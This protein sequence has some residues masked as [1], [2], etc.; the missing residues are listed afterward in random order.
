MTVSRLVPGVEIVAV[1]GQGVAVRTPDGDFLRVDTGE[2]AAEDLM[3]RLEGGARGSAALED[4][5][6]AFE[7][8]GYAGRDGE[9]PL[10]GR[11]VHLLG[12]VNL[13]ARLA[14][15]I[16]EEGADV[17]HAA[18]GEVAAMAENGAGRPAGA[19][20]AVVWCL[21]S[22]VGEGLWDAADRLPERGIGWLRC[23]REGFQAWIEPLAAAPG[24]VTSRD[25]RLRR[26]AAT[27]AHRELTAYWAGNRTAETGAAGGEAS[28]ALLA[29]LL[30]ADLVAWAGGRHR[31]G[32][33]P[34]R[35]RLRRVDLRD[36]TVT[37]HPVLPV[38]PVAPLPRTAATAAG[39]SGAAGR[40]GG[41]R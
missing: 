1:P 7:N 40:R 16:A 25:V 37:E 20:A 32:R 19:T 39:T 10:E 38:P 33:L 26:L 21:D 29:E 3:T 24:D 41:A 9:L 28:A 35:R 15:R 6:L 11:T 8:A 13:T 30:T 17:R 2:V 34:V 36:L 18:P 5:V 23:H 12:D 22:P 31:A 14:R 27:A 4:L